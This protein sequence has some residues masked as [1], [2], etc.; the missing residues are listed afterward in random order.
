MSPVY[1]L[2]YWA[3][4]TWPTHEIALAAVIFLRNSSELEKLG[5]FTVQDGIPVTDMASEK[6]VGHAFTQ[7]Q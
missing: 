1:C 5:A 4:G 2:G 6:S 3:I 7:K